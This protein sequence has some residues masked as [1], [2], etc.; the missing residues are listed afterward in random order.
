MLNEN[1]KAQGEKNIWHS[2]NAGNA[3]GKSQIWLCLAL[4]A[5]ILSGKK[6]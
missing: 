2:L 3:A 4:N 1:P 5:A 6:L